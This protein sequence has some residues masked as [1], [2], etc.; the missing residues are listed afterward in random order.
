MEAIRRGLVRRLAEMTVLLLVTICALSTAVLG[1]PLTRFDALLAEAQKEGKTDAGVEYNRQIAIYFERQVGPTASGCFE[2]TAKPETTPFDILIQVNG[3][4][5]AREVLMRPETNTAL[6]L[7]QALLVDGYPK[8]PA[9]S[10]WV[11]V[12][13]GIR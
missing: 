2:S 8:P 7:K 3:D 1:E 13:M 5:R 11:N 9:P 4:G 6:C 10:Y 12:R